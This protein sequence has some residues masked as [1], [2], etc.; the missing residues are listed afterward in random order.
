MALSF[1]NK[2]S[3]YLQVFLLKVFKLIY[4]SFTLN[5]AYKNIP[6]YSIS[7]QYR[8][9]QETSDPDLIYGELSIN[10]FLYLLALITKKMDIKIY[11]LGCGDGKLLLAAVLFFNNLNAIGI[12]RVEALQSTASNIALRLQ[13]NIAKNYCSLTFIKNSFLIQDFSDGDIILINGAA[14]KNNTWDELAECF[15]K[16]KRGT[17]VISVVRKLEATLFSLVYFGM[18]HCSWG[19]AWVYIYQKK[20]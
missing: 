2:V 10:S 9:T 16:L 8:D 11:D 1:Y 17:Y 14:L 15:K 18:H 12:E 5:N 19:K 4:V 3:A 7:K 20:I 13:P 6:T